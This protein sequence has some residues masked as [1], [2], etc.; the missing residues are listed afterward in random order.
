MG[1]NKNDYAGMTPH[2]DIHGSIGRETRRW[3]Q[4]WFYKLRGTDT[5]YSSTMTADEIF[6]DPDTI[7]YCY[8]LDP[9]G[10]YRT[11]T[12]SGSFNTG[13]IAFVKNTGTQYSIVFDPAGVKVVLQPGQ[14]QIFLYDGTTWR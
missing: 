4:G 8:F 9:N 5:Y 11:F 6:T 7:L 2:K 13:F 14:M 1:G 10:A 3:Y 12:P